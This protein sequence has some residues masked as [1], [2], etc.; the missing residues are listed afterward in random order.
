[1]SGEHE[2]LQSD[3]DLADSR[4]FSADQA[5]TQA[6]SQISALVVLL[7]AKG[8]ITQQEWDAALARK[9]EARQLALEAA[10]RWLMQS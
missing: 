10:Q 9:Q 4:A 7:I 3:I 8:V 1:M 2:R 6:G 5:A